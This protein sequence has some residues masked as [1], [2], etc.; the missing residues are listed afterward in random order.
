MVNHSEPTLIS[1]LSSWMSSLE[2]TKWLHYLSVLFRSATLIVN[3]I[4]NE[5]QS[6]LVH[7]S[8][9]WDRTAQLV[10]LAKLLMDPFYRTIKVL[11]TL[12]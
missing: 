5:G 10:S 7:C 8:D 1:F 11:L 12:F 9:G 3:A 2:A 6:V 4:R